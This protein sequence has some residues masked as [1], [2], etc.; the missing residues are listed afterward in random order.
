MTIE[1]KKPIIGITMGDAAGIGPE[2]ILK[3]LHEREV[4]ECCHPLLL[5]D[6]QVLAETGARLGLNV[7]FNKM[8]CIE[9]SKLS[10]AAINLIDYDNVDTSKLITGT[11]DPVCGEASYVYLKDACLLTLDGKLDAMVTAPVS[12][13]ALW[14]AGHQYEGQTQILGELC[15]VLKINMMLINEKLKVVLL[16]RHMSLI[17]AIK[18]ITA[19]LIFE[20][21]VLINDSF[22]EFG[23]AKPKIGVA[24]LN[25]HASETGIFGDEESKKIRPP[26]RRCQSMGINVDGPYPADTIFMRGLSGEFDIVLALYHDQGMIPIKMAGFSKPI[27]FILGLPIIRTSVGHGTAFDIAGRNIADHGSLVEAIKYASFLVGNRRK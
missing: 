8:E 1:K 2:I 20:T 9:T 13:E 23:L 7:D 18:S 5:G 26:I 14:L 3:A 22:S 4:Q 16:T 25:P 21:I 12:K 27:T 17:E 19:E 6:L 24:G 11:V 15:S 10:A